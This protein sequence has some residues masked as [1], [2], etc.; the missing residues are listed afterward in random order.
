MMLSLSDVL[1]LPP[2]TE[3]CA[4]T[5]PFSEKDVCSSLRMDIIKRT[6]E[7]W[8]WFSK[9]RQLDDELGERFGTLVYLPQEIRYRIFLLVMDCHLDVLERQCDIDGIVFRICIRGDTDAPARWR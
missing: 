8:I 6:E 5:L 4:M 1:K 3:M 7:R 9:T 2:T